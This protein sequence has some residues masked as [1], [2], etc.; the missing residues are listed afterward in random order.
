[1]WGWKLSPPRCG[2]QEGLGLKAEALNPLGCQTV[3]QW[4][5]NTLVLSGV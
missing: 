4:G 2:D 3:F 1:M 5:P